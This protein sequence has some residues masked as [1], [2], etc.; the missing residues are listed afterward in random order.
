MGQHISVRFWILAPRGPGCG[1]ETRINQVVKSG[2]YSV[3][4]AGQQNLMGGILFFEKNYPSSIFWK[5]N[6]PAQIFGEKNNPAQ[7]FTKKNCPTKTFNKKLC[8]VVILKKIVWPRPRIHHNIKLLGSSYLQKGVSFR[9][10]LSRVQF[11]GSLCS[12]CLK[13]LAF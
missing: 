2:L 7:N 11:F 4:G 5:K 12:P 8:P 6:N 10:T 13:K 1:L 9:L 3:L